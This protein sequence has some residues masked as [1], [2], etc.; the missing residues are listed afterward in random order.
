MSTGVIVGPGAQPHKAQADPWIDPAFWLIGTIIS[1]V[2]CFWFLLFSLSRPAV[3]PNPGLAAYTPP[4]AMRLVPLP[5]TSDAP[6]IPEPA[7]SRD[8]PS[9]L[10]AFAQPVPDQKQTKEAAP[11][12]HKRPR[13]VS[14]ESGERAFGYAQPW[15]HQYRDQYINRGWTSRPRLTGGPKSWF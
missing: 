3:Y 5:R 2:G 4:P 1:I 15:P 8:P 9:A 6:E 14:H 10:A 7:V 11:S 13:A 12:A